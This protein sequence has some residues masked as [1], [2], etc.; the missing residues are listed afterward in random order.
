M[1]SNPGGLGLSGSVGRCLELGRR[2]VAA[3]AVEPF[4]VD[5]VDQRA[6]GQLELVD[7]FP[8]PGASEP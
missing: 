7:S 3:A 8:G 2:D 5:P 6:G 1:A 4:V